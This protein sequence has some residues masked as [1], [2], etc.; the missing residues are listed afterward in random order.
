LFKI[1]TGAPMEYIGY[2]SSGESVTAVIK[3]EVLMTI[4][5]APAVS[6]HIRGGQVRALAIT[7]GNRSPD[8]PNLP[9]LQ[10]SGVPNAEVGLWSGIF[11]PAGTPPAIVRKLE[12]ETRRVLRLPEVYD[13]LLSLSVEPS[14]SSAEDF[15][16]VISADIE[17]WTAVAKAANIKIEP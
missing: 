12:A 2:K 16:K 3:G 10:E 17:R 6:G 7:S 13:R 14:G 5:D 4:V 9:T 1:R 8:F 15:A 11:A